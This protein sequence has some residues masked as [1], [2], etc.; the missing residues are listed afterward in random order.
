MASFDRG[1]P[2]WHARL[3]SEKQLSRTE[4]QL[5]LAALLA[6]TRPAALSAAAALFGICKRNG[7]GREAQVLTT[8]LDERQ[9][10]AQ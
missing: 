3:C 1:A 9:T 2:R 4:A 7:L 5:G 8:W 6:L 10:R